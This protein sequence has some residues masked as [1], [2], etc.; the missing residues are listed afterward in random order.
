MVIFR[1]FFKS[2]AVFTLAI[3]LSAC[4]TVMSENECA[5]ADWR[6]LGEL[7]GAQGLTFQQFDERTEA[8]AKFGFN[9]DQAAYDRGRYAGLERYCSPES[10]FET[11]RLGE[12]YRGVCR[13][14]DEE[15]FLSEFDLGLE[16]YRRETAY[17]EAIKNY[18]DAVQS[19]GQHK[20][21]L[22]VARNRIR[23]NNLANEDR[24]TT[25]RDIEYHR[26]EID[27]L[28]Y[29]LPLLEADIDR[30]GSE[31]DSFKESLTRA[32]RIL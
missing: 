8:C 3:S 23:V 25:Q 28:E 29:N 27:A 9:A 7:D 17:A 4:G 13:P 24:E 21:D 20:K 10:A 26:R 5:T 30:A 32:G 14:E 18:E 11:G 22:R 1:L 19:L 2:L 16:L 6:A 12:P 15:A 31:L